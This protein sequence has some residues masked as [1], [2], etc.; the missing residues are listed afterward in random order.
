MPQFA[1]IVAL[2]VPAAFLLAVFR[3]ARHW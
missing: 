1:F 3:L 2:A